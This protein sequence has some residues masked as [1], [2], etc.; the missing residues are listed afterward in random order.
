ML[1]LLGLFIVSRRLGTNWLAAGA[2][3]VMAIN[4]AISK[5]YSM[6]VSEGLVA[7]ILIWIMVLTLGGKRPIWQIVIGSMLAGLLV[8]IR[9]NM[10]PLLPLLVA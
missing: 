6:A 3:W 10:A 1:N 5:M 9:I 4:P 8:M 2:V 7:C